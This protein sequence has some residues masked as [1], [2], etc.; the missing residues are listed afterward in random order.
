MEQKPKVKLRLLG[1][2][3]DQTV[4]LPEGDFITLQDIDEKT[5]MQ[6]EVVEIS[7]PTKWRWL[8]QAGRWIKVSW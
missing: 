3:M 2:G 8:R 1:Q 7:G 4:E 5:I 6:V